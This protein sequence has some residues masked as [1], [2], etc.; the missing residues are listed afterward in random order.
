MK[1]QFHIYIASCTPDGGIYHYLCQDGKLQF[2]EK[3]DADRPMYLTVAEN[4]LYAVLRQPFTDSESSGVCWWEIGKDG[5]LTKPS[6]VFSTGGRC[7]C[8]LTVE[9]GKIY[10]ANYLSGSVAM[11]PEGKL[12]EHDGK[13][14]NPARQE[15]AHTHFVGMTPDHRYLLAVDLGTDT[16]YVYNPELTL[17]D[18]ILMPA[19]HGCRHLAW[20]EDGKYAFCVNELSSTVSTLRYEQGKLTLLGTVSAL[21]E[22]YMKENT[23]AAIR[24]ESNRVFVSNRGC[25]NIAIFTHQDGVLSRPVFVDA[26]GV[27]PRDFYVHGDLLLCANEASD[28]VSIFTCKD[29]Q[30]QSKNLHLQI[31]KPLCI[32]V[33]PEK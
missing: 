19:G 15:A 24:V 1:K 22:N 8:H 6:E 32:V 17:L 4:M 29:G 18:R 33:K 26:E 5:A 2:R 20:S 3:T 27:S 13:G 31:P 7:G 28:C 11:L 23:A 16:I 25:D 14:P 9:Q 30:L 12:V 10:V 21:S